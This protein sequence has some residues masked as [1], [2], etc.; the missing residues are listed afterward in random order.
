MGN[1]KTPDIKKK[2]SPALIVLLDVKW[3]TFKSPLYSRCCLQ[4]LTFSSSPLKT[5]SP[6]LSITLMEDFSNWLSNFA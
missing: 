3:L 5:G 6:E 1:K 2:K 4:N